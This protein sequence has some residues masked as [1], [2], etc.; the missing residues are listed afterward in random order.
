M[1]K[2]ALII[3]NQHHDDEQFRELPAATADA[4][5]LRAV[6][7]DPEIGGFQV[8]TVVNQTERTWRTK[9]FEFFGEAGPDDLLLLHLSCHGWKD[10]HNVLRF[11]ARDTERDR[12]EATAVDAQYIATWM[13]H[14]R[15]RRVVVLLDCC[16]SGAFI[17]GVRSR[18]EEDVDVRGSFGGKGRAVI[19]SSTSI[20]SAYEPT[21]D[22]LSQEPQSPSYF[23]SAVVEGLTTGR[24]D[25]DLDG[26]VSVD[27]LFGYLA[28][29]L[30]AVT[31][32]QNPTLS[33]ITLDSGLRLARNPN[34]DAMAAERA[35]A[36][37]GALVAE[38]HAQA[39]DE[40]RAEMEKQKEAWAAQLAS[41]E[42]AAKSIKKSLAAALGFFRIFVYRASVMSVVAFAMW[43]SS[44]TTTEL[45]LPGRPGQTVLA[46]AVCALVYPML[47]Y[48]TVTA[49]HTLVGLALLA[50]PVVWCEAVD[51]WNSAA[52]R[53]GYWLALIPIAAAALALVPVSFYWIVPVGLHVSAW[54]S[55]LAG[56]PVTVK[57]GWGSG[58][59]A[60]LVT[61]AW[62]L[63]Y[64]NLIPNKSP[65]VVDTVEMG[66]GRS[67]VTRSVKNGRFAFFNFSRWTSREVTTRRRPFWPGGGI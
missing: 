34:A 61:L 29:R 48:W 45:G 11:V 59:A 63:V 28:D 36:E 56:A 47:A 15:S 42:Q 16:Y 24:A 60:L 3:A 12:I 35:G 1:N 13:E 14:S 64:H 9:I 50:V 46:L 32:G 58:M 37:R 26:H 66:P 4:N 20:Q 5:A 65:D 30:P 57:W 25:L 38:A 31:A 41:A 51:D 23:T 8:T 39:R 21:A 53:T 43:V 10:L 55:G 7:A 17:K 67:V 49:V 27:D 19:T 6:L 22:S 33:V 62:L 44:T 54:I 40:A 52:K 18:G 2:K